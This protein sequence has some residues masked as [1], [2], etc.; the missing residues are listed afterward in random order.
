M[1]N[2]IR[3]GRKQR[4]VS[5]NPMCVYLGVFIVVGV[6]A[7]A[8][9]IGTLGH[10]TLHLLRLVEGIAVLASF[11]TALLLFGDVPEA[12]NSSSQGR[13]RLSEET[14]RMLIG[15]I[16]DYAIYMLDP[17]GLI[18]SWNEG[19]ERIKGY[20]PQEI[21]GRHFSCFYTPEDIALHH[22]Q[23]ELQVAA[24]EGRFED[25]GWR[26]RKDGSRFWADVVITALRDEAGKLRGFSKVTRD[27]T[28][29]KKAEQKFRGLLD[30]A[31]DAVV[32][33]NQEGKIVLV[34]AQVEKVF[35]Y[36]REELLG[37]QI[38]VLVPERFRGKHPGYR[39]GFF[40]EPRV[41][42]MGAALE[43]FALRKDATEFPVE[44]SLSPLETEEGVL[45]S[46][47]IR[48]ITVRKK[49]EQ[50]FRGLLEAAPDAMV[51]VNREGK[52]V[53]A[54]AQ[55]EKLFGYQ[56]EELL[57]KDI[58]ILVPER[59]RS[60]HPGH[61]SDFFA[62]PRVRPMGAG[63]ELYGVR[64]DG[65]EFPVEISLSPLETEEGVL[66][67]SAIRD[68]TDRKEAE[69]GIR[70]LNKDLAQRSAELETTNKELEA[71]TYSVSHDLRAPLRAVDGFSQVLVEDYG[72]KFD[73]EGRDYLG[74]VRAATQRMGELIDGLLSLARLTRQEIYLET[75]DLSALAG[76]V[77]QSL[78]QSE[79]DRPVDFVIAE[80]A[81]VQGDRRLLEVVLQN[82]LANAWKFTR[83]QP[84]AR[85]EF[86]R[87]EENGRPVFFVRDNGAGFDMAYA[88]KLF[89]AFQRLHSQGEFEGHGIGLA[90][91]QRVIRRHGGCIW[92]EGQVGKGAT[93]SFT[94]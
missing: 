1:P 21:I 55:V 79:P 4:D 24:R 19:A 84:N 48:D 43:L 69:A 75:V 65:T 29:R 57:G 25:E 87:G 78:R 14:Y 89:G 46:S 20:R 6:F 33:V 58:E 54:N 83:K 52:I 2:G 32:V 59:F 36:R 66:V 44:I 5:F 86:G 27:I 76:W 61:R 15:Q 93:F 8:M 71:F 17:E 41:R 92:A 73:A 31:P 37:K 18:M 60:R 13:M 40:A 77:A 34:N 3:T 50:K 39:A 62:E 51:V 47:A 16:K 88:G 42:E 45:V 30:A 82:L 12:D 35:G 11:P 63:L 67:S 26:V 70:Q 56:R 72:E 38:E 49:A 23:E 53:L 9:G 85:I 91:A 64:K 74:R 90:T 80:G 22:P 81:R 68:I 7:H 94:L 28:A 10:V